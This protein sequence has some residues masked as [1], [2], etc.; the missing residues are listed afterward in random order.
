MAQGQAQSQSDKAGKWGPGAW[1]QEAA[2]HNVLRGMGQPARGGGFVATQR[3]GG[4]GEGTGEEEE[5]QT[6]FVEKQPGRPQGQQGGEREKREETE[7]H[8]GG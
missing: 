2:A 7:T 5:R 4:G 1:S 8:S 6:D 3:Q